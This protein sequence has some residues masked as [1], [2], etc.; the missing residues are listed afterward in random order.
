M[1]ESQL[2]IEEF[3][4]ELRQKGKV[5]TTAWPLGASFSPLDA[6]LVEEKGYLFSPCLIDFID[7]DIVQKELSL[8][9]VIMFEAVGSTNSEMLDLAKSNSVNRTLCFSEFQYAGRGRRGRK[10]VSPYGRNL[11]LSIGFET[12]R[13]ISTVSGL[14]LVAGLAIADTLKSLGIFNVR[15]KW[16]NDLI[17]K[18]IKLAGI[19]VELLEK[20]NSRAVVVGVGVN[21]DIS[22]REEKL[23]DQAITDVRSEGI[24]IS[25]TQLLCELVASVE[26]EITRFLTVGFAPFLSRYESLLA[27]RDEYCYLL[28][29]NRILCE[30]IL[31]GVNMIGELRIRTKDGTK[32]FGAGEVSLRRSLNS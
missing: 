17:V 25:R 29:G 7:L 11:A 19:L 28:V 1:I 16:P 32:T 2:N 15:L 6:G 23:I 13:P 20:E 4:R 30:G 12:E 31:L 3:F 22:D 10:W 26:L 27:Y 18:G 14:S 24:K 9:K 21:V 5:V 8:L